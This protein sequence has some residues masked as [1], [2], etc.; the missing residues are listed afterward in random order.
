M[1]KDFQSFIAR[2]FFSENLP[3]EGRI[4]NLVLGFGIFASFGAMIARIIE[5]VSLTA[6]VAVGVM[7]VV[8]IITFILCNKFRIYHV[9][10]WAALI[11]VCDVL[12][13]LIFFTNGGT[14]SGMA[15]Y[16]VLTIVLI[17][18]LLRGMECLI[19]LCLH[20]V[21]V[22]GCY[23]VERYYPS[24]VTPFTNTFQ[25]YVDH[26]QT[27]FV[28]GFFIGLVIK[29]QT[30]IY[31]NEKNKAEDA[32]RA[33]ADFLANV[34]HEIRTPLNAIIGLGELE[35]R[36]SLPEETYSNMEKIHNSGMVLLSI[37]N[38][39]L[40]I[41]KIESGRFELIPVNYQMASFINDTV[42]LNVVR[43]GSKPIAFHLRINE[44]LPSMLYG[45]EIRI[46]QIL[47]NLLS[48][49]FKYTREGK[50][51]LEI[52]FEELEGLEKSVALI[53]RV[54]DTG[55]GIRQEDIGK[56]FSV[57]NQ[58]D[59]RSN[60][61]IE[62]T[63][64]GLS[65]SK[66]LAEMMNGE[67]TVESEYGWGSVFT[68]RI[69]QK[70]ADSQPLGRDTKERLEHFNYRDG[71]RR[72][73]RERIRVRMPY[74]RV[75]VVDD[76][77][78]NLDVAKGMM[79]PYGLTIDCAISGKEAI[80]LIREAKVRYNAIF[81]DHMMPEMDG[82][83]AVRV[84][85]EKIGTEYAKTVPIIALTANAIIGNDKMFL[86]KG[87][88]DYLSKPIDTSK[89]DICLNRWVRDREQEARMS[90]DLVDLP[91]SELKRDLVFA[92]DFLAP[93]AE[94]PG[95]FFPAP[96]PPPSPLIEGLDFDEGVRRMGGRKEVFL[97]VLSSYAASMP[98]LLDKIRHFDIESLKD[99]TIT[100][101]GIKGSCYGICAT[102][103]G[104]QAEALEMAAKREDIETILAN[105][106]NLIVQVEALVRRIGDFL[107]S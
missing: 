32:T 38:D 30:R 55:I 41:S 18:L 3:L 86:E 10:I 105:N 96:V 103:T 22:V 93:D 62:G 47:N 76:V 52:T 79:L 35:L 61:H 24:L 11:T 45:D 101:H 72:D 82:I 46:R 63:G 94:T 23:L 42:H 21:V 13:P 73:R 59:T 51:T 1:E 81:M 54:E 89:L 49:A 69:R 5:G 44:D 33:K 28:S 43:I 6:I 12:F 26:I 95:P 78:T 87:F 39:L 15:G 83:E 85:R 77:A 68:L 91:E 8:I 65:I 92:R 102:D 29:Y 37:I 107:S 36:K 97:R 40:D 25:Q 20:A 27:I 106:D 88:Q 74:A 57:Y 70:V 19:M 75:L 31:E 2:Y 66:N 48:N 84:I 80:D 104:K 58:V 7:I 64:L 90:P 50:V 9:G 53:C 4:F 14:D 56:L 71:G 17:F 60:R 34:S 100:V 99:Y 16:F 98:A 67:I